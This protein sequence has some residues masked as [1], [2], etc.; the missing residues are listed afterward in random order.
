M[1][2][3]L[4][5]INFYKIY[6]I[7]HILILKE[8]TQKKKT[9]N[10]VMNIRYMINIGYIQTLFFITLSIKDYGVNQLVSIG[11]AFLKQY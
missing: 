4:L 3:V 1:L 2:F 6:F 9:L 11:N 7:S 10:E 5:L 8:K